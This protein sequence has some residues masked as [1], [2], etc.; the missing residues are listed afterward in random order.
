MWLGVL[1]ARIAWRLAA[2]LH[3]FYTL[4]QNEFRGLVASRAP[5]C[6]QGSRP[7]RKQ[8]SRPAGK[9]LGAKD[10]GLPEEDGGALR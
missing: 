10:V 7:T 2:F 4:S 6:S 5:R 9:G 8:S 1:F 3:P